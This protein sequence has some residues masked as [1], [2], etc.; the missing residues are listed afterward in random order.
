MAG[1][2]SFSGFHQAVGKVLAAAFVVGA[3]APLANLF[4]LAEFT[5]LLLQDLGPQFLA[6]CQPG[7]FLSSMKPSLPSLTCGPSI[8]ALAAELWIC[9]TVSSPARGSPLL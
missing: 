5:S 7:A 4:L 8:F 2:A 9:L 3:P 6:S 1:L